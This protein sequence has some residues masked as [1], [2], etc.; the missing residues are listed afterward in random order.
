MI[1][2]KIPLLAT[3]RRPIATLMPEENV[4]DAK[5]VICAMF[6]GG[7]SQ[8]LFMAIPPEMTQLVVRMNKSPDAIR[9]ER[10]TVRSDWGSSTEAITRDTF[11]RLTAITYSLLYRTSTSLEGDP[12]NMG[13]IKIAVGT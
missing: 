13:L 3:S 6:T 10:L 1:K 12:M 2:N 8:G 11:S 5:M 4:E 7:E 9:E